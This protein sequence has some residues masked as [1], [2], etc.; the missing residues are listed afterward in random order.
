MIN[1]EYYLDMAIF[2]SINLGL[3]ISEIKTLKYIDWGNHK[4]LK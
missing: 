1:N 4:N 3:K 2:E